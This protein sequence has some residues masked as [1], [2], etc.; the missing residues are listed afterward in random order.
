MIITTKQFNPNFEIDTDILILLNPSVLKYKVF[1]FLTHISKFFNCKVKIII[2]NFFSCYNIN[3]I[4]L[5]K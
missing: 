5:K 2:F 1:K 4:F 3:H